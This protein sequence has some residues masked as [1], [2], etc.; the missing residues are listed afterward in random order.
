MQHRTMLGPAFAKG[1]SR[2]QIGSGLRQS[3]LAMI[4]AKELDG[5]S[6]FVRETADVLA[7]LARGDSVATDTSERKSEPSNEIERQ[8]RIALQSDCMAM[9]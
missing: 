1:T 4:A 9:R 7:R 3:V 8:L 6:A 5:D 2:A